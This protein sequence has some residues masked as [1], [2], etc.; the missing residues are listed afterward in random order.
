MADWLVV[1]SRHTR[2][3]DRNKRAL[4]QDFIAV[5]KAAIEGRL[6]SLATEVRGELAEVSPGDTAWVFWPDGDV[7]VM[8]MG[9]VQP[10]RA[11]RGGPPQLL[12]TFDRARTRVLAI[13]PLPASLV[14]RWLPDLR[15]SGSMLD[16]RPRALDSVR[17]WEQER[18]TRDD[19][20]LRPLHAAPWRAAAT[21]GTKRAV[22]NPVL[23]S[24]V[25]FLRSQDFAVGVATRH[26]APRIIARRSRDVLVVHAAGRSTRSRSE[27]A[28]AAFGRLCEHRWSIERLSPDLHVQVRSWLAF[29]TRPPG[30]AVAFLEDQGVF[31]TWLQGGRRVEMTQRS[32]HR[33]YEQLGAR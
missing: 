9:R 24:V 15:K 31:V 18:A 26:A 13:D 5:R 2:L 33:W 4:S 1:V 3:L 25:P 27:D 8:G 20:L 23:A 10:P 29:T 28:A 32:R 16:V 30:D 11:R 22:D 21:R 12:V 7:G 19:A 6:A 14:R 17:G